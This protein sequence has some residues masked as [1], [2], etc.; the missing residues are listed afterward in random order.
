MIVLSSLKYINHI[1]EV[2]DLSVSILS[3]KTLNNRTSNKS[4]YSFFLDMAEIWEM[5]LLKVFQDKFSSEGWSVT[6]EI[7]QTYKG[8]FYSRK[9][10]PYIVLRKGNK[11]AFFDAKYK[12]MRGHYLD[13]YRVDFFQIHTYKTYYT[14]KA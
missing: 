14:K 12:L 8:T 1:T 10:I 11:M 5:Y 4:G 6:S 2:V 3:N 13:V 7:V 9:L